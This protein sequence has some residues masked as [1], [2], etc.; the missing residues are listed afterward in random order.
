MFLTLLQKTMYYRLGAFLSFLYAPTCPLGL[1]GRE[2]VIRIL[3]QNTLEFRVALLNHQ[4]KELM[5]LW[6]V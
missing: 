3:D 2:A 1:M 4:V 5:S 6:S